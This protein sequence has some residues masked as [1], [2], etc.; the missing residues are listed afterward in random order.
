MPDQEKHHYPAR[1]AAAI[2]FAVAFAYVEATVVVYLRELIYP[3]GFHFP[4]KPIPF[5]LLVIELLREAFTIVMLAAAAFLC[6]R[7]FW[8][9][10]GY[11]LLIFG[12]WDIFYYVWLKATID[13]PLSLLDWDVLFLI[14]LPWIG[15]VVAPVMVSALMIVCGFLITRLYARGLGLA[16][17]LLSWVLALAATGAILFSFMRD[18]SATLGGQIPEPYW[19][20]LLVIGLVLFAAGFWAAY[21]PARRG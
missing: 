11:F 17:T 20:S 6:G 14:P 10:F 19:Y 18:L 7:P 13:W 9:G 8:H 3:E 1:L 21:A 16:P 5:Q 12:V 2:G 15:P 4:L